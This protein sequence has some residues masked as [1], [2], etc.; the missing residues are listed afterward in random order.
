MSIP[1]GMRIPPKIGGLGPDGVAAW[2]KSVG[3]E[4]L[5]LGNINAESKAVLDRHGLRLGTVDAAGT[6][7]LLSKDPARQ[8]KGR[9]ALIARID[10]VAAQGGKTIFICLVPGEAMSRRDSFQLWLEL[11]P[12]IVAHAES[13]GVSFAI[14]GWPGGA[15]VYPTVGYTPEIFRAMFKACPSPALGLC[16]DPSHLVRLGIDHI[17]FLDEFGSRVRHCHGKDTELLPEGQYLYGWLPAILDKTPGF[18]EGPWRY[19]IPG[20]GTVNWA[21]VAYRLEQ[22]GYTGPI[23]IELEDARYWGSLEKEQ[24]GIV[25]A[26]EFLRRH[27]K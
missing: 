15:P 27:A 12:P 24:Q 19:C 8:E 2:A 14:E 6:G 25:K 11:F 23:S 26:A 5:D 7:D 1:I 21:R 4:A 18:S 9:N 20:D 16:Y 10:D 3:L 22:H 13:K 17:R